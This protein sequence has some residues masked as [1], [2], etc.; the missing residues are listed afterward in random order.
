MKQRWQFRCYP[1][2]KQKH[3]LAQIFGCTRFVYNHF[4]FERTKAFKDGQSMNYSQS[5][6]ALTELK[7]LP[8][9][10]W[11]ND[12]SSV[13]LQQSLR[14]LQTAFRNFF[15][16]RTGYPVFK[17]KSG[18]QSA[19]YTRSA[20]RF[21]IGNQRLLIAKTGKLKVKWSRRISEYPTTTT[22]I[23]KPSGRYF[24][25]LVVDADIIQLPK[26]GASVGIDFGIARLATL[27]TG[28]RISNPKFLNRYQKRMVKIQRNL[29]RKQKGSNRFKRCKQ[30]LAKVHEK[31]SDSRNDVLNKLA[32]NLVNRFDIIHIEDLNLRGM[33]KNH[34]LARS[35]SDA[36]IGSSI[37]K[38]KTKALMHGKQVKKIDRWFPSSKLCCMCGAIQEKMPLSVRKWTCECGAVH[39]RDECAAI[40]ILKA[41]QALSARGDDVRLALA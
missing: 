22:I 9:Y 1:T 6:A 16:K 12:V 37:R 7:K 24:V 15:D 40:N 13:P 17:K 3:V 27:S 8:E 32:W 33:A 30:K 25:S 10:N 20:F 19:E 26:T 39:D 11:L 2:K 31:I 34:C 28:E 21:E 35:L 4:L 14:N 41:G 29:S 23:R 5:S 38:I 18:K 36:S